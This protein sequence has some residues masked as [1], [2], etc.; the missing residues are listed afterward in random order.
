MET[1]IGKK[2][3]QL[4]N[5][6]AFA[7]A[8]KTCHTEEDL[9]QIFANEGIVMDDGQFAMLM[10]AL[11]EAAQGPPEEELAEGVL[12]DVAGGVSVK[13]AVGWVWGAM[14]WGWHMGNRFYEWEQSLYRKK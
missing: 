2:V 14:K 13:N 3:E 1:A 12:D 10:E 8:M 7:E 11:K 5:S 9:R 4:L 6:E